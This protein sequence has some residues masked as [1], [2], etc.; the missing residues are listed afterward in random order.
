MIRSLLFIATLSVAT[1]AQAADPLP[2]HNWTTP[3]HRSAQSTGR[4]AY[5]TGNSL[6]DLCR[7]DEFSCTVYIQGVLDG[8]FSTI[9]ATSRD[10]AYCIPESSKPQQVKDVVVAYLTAHPE[11]RHLL[12]A[13]LITNALADAWPQCR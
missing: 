8:Q 6:F 12:A 1:T 10:V 7:K 2:P 13:G 4:V 11:R 9:V 5:Y 3:P